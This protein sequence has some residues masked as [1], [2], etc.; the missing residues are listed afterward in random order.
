MQ[1]GLIELLLTRASVNYNNGEV[2]AYAVRNFR[3]E[4]F[5]LLLSQGMGY[6][7]LF[8]ALLEALKAPRPDRAILFRELLSRLQLDHLNTAL[9]H[10]VLE[11]KVDLPLAKMLLDSG[12]ESTHEDGV[13]IK[14]AAANLDRNLLS[15]LSEYSGQS[16][17]IYTQA[18]AAVI[19]RN[20]QW[21]AFEHVDVVDIMLRSGASNQIASRAMVEIV[22]H[23]VC[24]ESQQ[25]LAKTLL[26]KLFA[27]NVDVNSGNGKVIS[28]AASRGD[29]RLLSYLLANG[30]TSSS[31]TLALTAAIMAHHGEA[32]LLQMI[33][34]FVTQ[35]RAAPDFNR[36]LP[37]MPP[38]VL[39]CLKSYGESVAILD[40]LVKAGCHLGA[41]V[42][43]QV[44]SEITEDEGGEA[45]SLG[46][47]SVPVLM[48]AL[49]QEGELISS[50]VVGALL[51]HGGEYLFHR[52]QF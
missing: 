7:A 44:C 51:R 14:H 40:S 9:K 28:I 2:F 15:L 3:L 42:P 23:L 27:V 8:T 35:R 50:A 18:F 11:E 48:W 32:L 29:P 10:I 41:T 22:D 34:I 20:K 33:E 4:S 12:A 25:D 45:F 26:G 5:H 13:C 49:L 38:P 47:E 46:P 37:G 1:R 36:S 17:P 6:K 39:L 52:R 24:R 21:I 30:A 43:M 16:E 19:N 31:A